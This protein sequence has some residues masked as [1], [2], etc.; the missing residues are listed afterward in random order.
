MFM[1]CLSYQGGG[2]EMMELAKQDVFLNLGSAFLYIY[3]C[4]HMTDLWSQKQPRTIMKVSRLEFNV[5]WLNTW[6]AA[7][8]LCM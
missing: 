8:E 3:S 5:S 1:I 4:S 2:G 6:C 7:D